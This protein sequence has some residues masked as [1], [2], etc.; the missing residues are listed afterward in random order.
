M[1]DITGPFYKKFNNVVNKL[2]YLKHSHI[3]NHNLLFLIH[4]KSV[5]FPS[6]D[7]YLNANC[8]TTKMHIC[9][10]NNISTSNGANSVETLNS[11]LLSKNVSSLPQMVD[12]ENSKW[13]DCNNI[14][15]DSAISIGDNSIDWQNPI[16]KS[17]NS[18]HHFAEQS[19]SGVDVNKSSNSCLSFFM[20]NKCSNPTTSTLISNKKIKFDILDNSSFNDEHFQY[21]TTNFSKKIDASEFSK[22]E[23][24]DVHNVITVSPNNNSFSLKYRKNICYIQNNTSMTKKSPTPMRY[25]KWR[26][27]NSCTSVHKIATFER[28]KF[29]RTRSYPNILKCCEE[30]YSDTF[31]HNASSRRNRQLSKSHTSIFAKMNTFSFCPTFFGNKQDICI[32]SYYIS[33]EKTLFKERYT[34][35]SNPFLIPIKILNIEHNSRTTFTSNKKSC[36]V[37]TALRDTKTDCTDLKVQENKP[38][39]VV[40]FVYI[41]FL[42]VENCV[43]VIL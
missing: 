30:Q 13:T 21:E 12:A 41:F 16:I 24:N 15:R 33:P 8:N 11:Y 35:L 5:P 7:P 22:S 2:S 43:V 29:M 6:Y 20:S 9:K 32:D 36:N 18:F 26:K 17:G 42:F 34:S 19:D 27:T 38:S 1:V 14:S 39:F 10:Y 28:Y 31:L 40:F 37:T 25:T 4:S 23:K 3:N